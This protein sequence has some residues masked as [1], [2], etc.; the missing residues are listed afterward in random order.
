M[1]AARWRSGSAATLP[2]DAQAGKLALRLTQFHAAP[3]LAA[4]RNLPGRCHELGEDRAGQ[5]ALDLTGNMRLVFEPANDPIPARDDGGLDWG[6]VT[7]VRIRE[8][9][10]YHG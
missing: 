4:M 8:V 6:R 7:E 2:G 1:R 9:T 10:D 5:V 3:N